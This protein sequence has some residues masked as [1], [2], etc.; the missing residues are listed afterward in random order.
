L[1]SAGPPAA[2]VEYQINQGV[3][4]L[5]HPQY[6]MWTIVFH[7]VAGHRGKAS[8]AR[9]L[10][11][12]LPSATRHCLQAGGAVIK[13]AAEEDGDDAWAVGAGGAAKQRINGRPVAVFTRARGHPYEVGFEQQMP[14]WRR[15]VHAGFPGR[16]AVYGIGHRQRAHAADH[17][18]EQARPFCG[19][20]D[21]NKNGGRKVAGQSGKDPLD[22][23]NASRRSA[24]YDNVMAGHQEVR[25]LS[26]SMGW[27]PLKTSCA[28]SQ[29]GRETPPPGS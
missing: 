12:C 8:L 29:N 27:L 21:G 18:R 3:R 22:G 6:I 16:L 15:E 11:D 1:I 4:E 17:L 13:K 24:H 20:V 2:A 5:P 19:G 7:R 26:W 28:G 9:V 14:V 23:R 25:G 10:D